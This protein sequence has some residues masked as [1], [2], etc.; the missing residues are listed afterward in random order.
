MEQNTW[1]DTFTEILY[2]RYPK[3]KQLMEALMDLLGLEREASYRRLRQEVLFSIDEIVTIAT[4]W[5]ISLDEITKVH[6]GKI[7]FKMQS[8][9]YCNPLHEEVKFFNF[10]IQSINYLKDFPHTEFMDICNRLPIQLI[11]GFE[12]LNKFFLFKSR[13]LQENESE[14]TPFSEIN[15]SQEALRLAFEYNQAIKLAPRTNYIFDQR[16]FEYLINDVQYFCSIYLLNQE[17]KEL[18]KKEAFALLD[19]MQEMANKGCYPETQNKVNIYISQLKIETG[20]CYTATPDLDVFYIHVF[21]KLEL[22][23]F[24]S[25]MVANFIAWMQLKK[26]AS[27]QISEVD[28]KSRIEFFTKQRQL[29]ESL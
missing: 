21:D 6:S 19:Y 16:I 29:L 1:F 18:I 26:R 17:E 27:I 10:I 14:S 11:S 28:A 22:Y 5:N 25:E 4:A 2:K 12:Q 8:L 13:Y 3:R 7:L 20:Y 24:H 9:N 15:I 23:S